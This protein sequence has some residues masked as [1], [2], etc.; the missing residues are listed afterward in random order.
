[1]VRQIYVTSRVVQYFDIFIHRDIFNRDY[2]I[3]DKNYIE[4]RFIEIDI[5]ENV[6]IA[7][8]P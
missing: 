4:Q 2:R 5:A 3:E 6:N 8:I 1:M 7:F